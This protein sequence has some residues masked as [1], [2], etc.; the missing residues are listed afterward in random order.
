MISQRQV[1][2]AANRRRLD[3]LLVRSN[4]VHHARVLATVK[5]H[6]ESW[7]D[8]L[9]VFS[10][11]LLLPDDAVRAGVAFRLSTPVCLPHRYRCG[12][13]ADNLGHHQ[14]SCH[15]DPGRLPRH[16]ALNDVIHCGLAAA[17]IPALLELRGL[18]QSD[19]RRLDGVILYPFSGGRSLLWDVTCTNNFG[20]MKVTN[21]AVNPGAAARAV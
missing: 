5:L 2:E 13:A 19:G 12:S 1:D 6:S 18:D 10:L 21:C 16:A 9:P 4:Q 15:R 14:L 20:N 8:A 7:I 17:V 3:E 11:G